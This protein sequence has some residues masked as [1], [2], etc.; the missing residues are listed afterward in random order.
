MVVLALLL[1]WITAMLGITLLPLD[2]LG[3]WYGDVTCGNTLMLDTSR[4]VVSF[5]NISIL[6]FTLFIASNF[7][8]TRDH[9]SHSQ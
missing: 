6:S 4:R 8:H 5:I 9:H 7:L 3:A 1:R 2:T